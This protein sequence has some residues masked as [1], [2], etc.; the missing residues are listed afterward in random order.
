MDYDTVGNL[1]NY[2]FKPEGPQADRWG[3]DIG[4]WA[5]MLKGV[6]VGVTFDVY[7][8]SRGESGELESNFYIKIVSAT[9]AI[10]QDCG[11]KP[12]TVSI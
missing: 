2:P 4:D 6:R 12:F 8:T 9:E 5:D 3:G 10:C 7:L 1:A 11:G